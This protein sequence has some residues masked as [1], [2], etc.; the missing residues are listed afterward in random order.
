[1]DTVVAMTDR[2]C[3]GCEWRAAG[4][5]E[6]CWCCGGADVEVVVRLRVPSMA[7]WQEEP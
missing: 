7:T 6:T 5:A 1:M 3:R 4:W 2:H